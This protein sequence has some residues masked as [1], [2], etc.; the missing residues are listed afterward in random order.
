MARRVV[1]A[2]AAVAALG[3]AASACG[4]KPAA[5]PG[6]IAFDARPHAK[7]AYGWQLWVVDHNGRGLKRLTHTDGDTTPSWS[8]DASQV[9]FERFESYCQGTSLACSRIW[10]VAADGSAETPLTPANGR[11]GAPDW[12]PEGGRIAYQRSPADD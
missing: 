10:L 9:A 5:A 6:L 12:A 7:G 8:P 3:M 4:E 1:P 2:L 11:A